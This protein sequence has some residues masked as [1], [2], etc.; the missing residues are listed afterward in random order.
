MEDTALMHVLKKHY[1]KMHSPAL[2]TRPSSP[3][4]L[5]IL[6][7]YML[8]QVKRGDKG[9]TLWERG[10]R[11]ITLV[12]L[13]NCLVGSIPANLLLH[14]NTSSR[15]SAI[16]NE[17]FLLGRRHQL[18][19]SHGSMIL[20]QTERIRRIGVLQSGLL[21]KHPLYNSVGERMWLIK[22]CLYYL[23]VRSRRI[24]QKLA[25]QAFILSLLASIYTEGKN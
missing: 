24:L 12:K 2:S 7:S 9:C 3:V 15:L 17:I 11:I 14:V 18:S 13:Y 1:A 19:H 25:I 23:K 4:H 16:V 20:Y 10:G 8:A 22:M 21:S 6:T 5:N